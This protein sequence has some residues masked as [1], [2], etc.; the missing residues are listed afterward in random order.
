[1]TISYPYLI[2]GQ[3][4][5]PALFVANATGVLGAYNKALDEVPE[6]IVD[7]TK[8]IAGVTIVSLWTVRISP[9]GEPQLEIAYPTLASKML[10]FT[11]YGG[12][13]GCTYTMLINT[14]SDQG[15]IR[16]DVL[17]VNVQGDDCGS[18]QIVVPAQ[19][20]NQVSGDGGVFINTSPR[21]FCQWHTAGWGQCIGSLV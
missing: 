14:A 5:N 15:N 4:S 2:P 3:Q 11:L 8:L 1:M 17:T 6:I 21:F 16:S 13:A 20:I 12:I 10:T 19:G 7:Y 18:C 9:G